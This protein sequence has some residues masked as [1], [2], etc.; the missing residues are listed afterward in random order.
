[1]LQAGGVKWVCTEGGVALC[2]DD[3]V[4][5]AHKNPEDAHTWAYMVAASADSP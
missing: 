2:H 5:F 3:Y 4:T 1:M